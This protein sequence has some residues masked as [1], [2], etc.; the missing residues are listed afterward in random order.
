MPN[1]PLSPEVLEALRQFD[2]PTIANGIE[3]FQVRDNVEGYASLELRCLFPDRK[4]MLGYAVTCTADTS[5]PG[6]TR[7]GG[8]GRI[9][10]ALESAPRP[11]VLVIQHTGHDRLRSCMAGDMVCT[12]LQAYGAAGLVTDAGIRDL[13]GI[14]ARTQDFQLFAAGFVVAHGHTAFIDVNVPVSICGLPIKPGDVLHGDDSG[15]VSIP[16]QIAGQLADAAQ[17]VRAREKEY[18][19]FMQSSDFNFEGLRQRLGGHK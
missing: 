6:D 11:A 3:H 19:D 5:M 12:G 17:A 15:L 7:P 1:T 8:L 18:F 9:W 10:E 13:G 2:S 4:P 16:L 14:R